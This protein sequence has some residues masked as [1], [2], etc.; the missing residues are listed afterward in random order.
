MRNL[1]A[2]GSVCILLV[3]CATTQQPG[4]A[5]AALDQ[6]IQLTNA[7]CF[8]VVAE[9]PTHDSLTYD[10]P[11]NW[12]LVD[13]VTRNDKYLP[14][15][16]AFAI[17]PT[18]LVTSAHVLNLTDN[19]LVYKTRFIREKV[20]EAGKTVERLYEVDDIHAFDNNRDYVVFTV[21]GRTFSTWLK[22][23]PEYK[24][25]SKV[26]TAG[27][28]YGEGIV[29]R[30]G[31]LLD[32]VPE[33]ENGAWSFL[34]SSIATNPGN[35]GGPLL[36][37]RFEVIGIVE[38]RRDDFCYSLPMSE[39]VPNKAVIHS[40]VTFG[41]VVFNKRKPNTLDA[42]W[43]LP[44]KYQ[45]VTKTFWDKFMPF[46]EQSMG[47]LLTENEKEMFP[48]GSSSD[49][50][51]YGS[52]DR[53]FPQIYLQDSTTGKWFST[54]VEVSR[55]D[56]G[57]NGSVGTAEIYKD[58]AVWLVKLDAPD[59]I[60]V[61]RLVDEP[62]LAMDT[63]LRGI[64]ITRK[65][66]ES[67]QGSRV[68]SYGAPIQTMSQTDRWGRVWQ[69]NVYLLEYS[70][71][72]VITAS[73]PTPTGLSMVYKAI[74]SEGRDE[75]LF[76]LK[77]I[78]DLVNVSYAG[79]LSQWDTFLKQPDF[80]SA[81]MKNVSVTWTEGRSVKVDAAGFS[82]T[83]P[84]GLVPISKDS[85]LDLYCSVFLRRGAPVLDVRKLVFSPRNS[86]SGY[87]TFYRWSKPSDS[88]PKAIQDDWRKYILDAGHPYSGKVYTENGQT[89]LGI[90]HPAFLAGKSPVVGDFAYT[91][92]VAK[93]G[94]VT[95]QEMTRYSQEFARGMT[96]RE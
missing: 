57:S 92:F 38:A 37:E 10:K 46:Y 95:E 50:A 67:D 96:I 51:L 26:Y 11:L 44:M 49:E 27:D 72:V 70:D 35:S 12:D 21:K 32:T 93:E 14:L 71:Q 3:S 90:L 42:S 41:F 63:L 59:D 16:T 4:S 33:K 39:I 13:Y 36:N 61:R 66:T 52:V 30:E 29:V 78:V 31:T 5:G 55:S 48:R 53:R 73:L 68:T 2:L 84:D 69:I 85:F 40:R 75:W 17:S 94:V 64:N 24:L 83:L 74:G 87:Y 47:S 65:L 82:S 80:R 23:A 22:T 20:K 76:D 89:C 45:E 25:N 34:K 54:D 88:L 58:A 79:T 19:S 1:L 15:G 77:R 28:A 8:E 6:R 18:E 62:R 81:A 91:L 7:T 60:P 43:P 56:I 9:K 86:S